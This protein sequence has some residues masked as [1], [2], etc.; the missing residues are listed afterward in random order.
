MDAAAQLLQDEFPGVMIN[1][2]HTVFLVWP[3][4]SFEYGHWRSGALEDQE[5]SKCASWITLKDLTERKKHLALQLTS[6]FNSCF[7]KEH[8]QILSDEGSLSVK[9]RLKRSLTGI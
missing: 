8:Y 4:V 5:K 6:K 9:E 2:E 1:D 7:L 3:L